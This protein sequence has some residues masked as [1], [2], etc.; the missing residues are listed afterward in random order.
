MAQKG[1]WIAVGSILAG[2]IAMLGIGLA[3][4]S[5]LGL[6]GPGSD[7]PDFEAI[8]VATGETRGLA[9]YEGDVILLNIWATWCPACEE[10]MPSMQR[11]YERLSPQGLKV[12]AVSIDK[13]DAEYVLEWV[14]E[15]NLTFDILQ[16]RAGRIEDIYQTTGVPESFVIDRNGVI[17]KKVIGA[18]EW[19]HPA[20]VDL[21]RRLLGSEEGAQE[22]LQP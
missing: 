21:L 15:R 5:D 12:V 13:A 11:L 4:T 14:Q 7:A 9:D 22:A 17:V 18:S 10:E 1:Q 20:Q 3:S 2:F 16:D 19:D 6:V 8:D